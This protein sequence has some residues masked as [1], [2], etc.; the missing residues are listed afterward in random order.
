MN[1]TKD[2]LMFLLGVIGLAV[3]V[4]FLAIGKCT[5]VVISNY[6]NKNV[7]YLIC[8]GELVGGSTTIDEDININAKDLIENVN[9][10]DDNFTYFNDKVFNKGYNNDKVVSAIRNRL[11][12][13]GAN[14]TVEDDGLMF[15]GFKW[16]FHKFLDK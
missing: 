15:V 2:L 11:E 9:S 14:V 16:I 10:K 5:K 3:L 4:G 1:K 8:K 7:S 13:R 12:P 6:E